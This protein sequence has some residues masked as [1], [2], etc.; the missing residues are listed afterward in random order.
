MSDH[1]VSIWIVTAS[2]EVGEYEPHQTTAGRLLSLY[3]GMSNDPKGLQQ[4]S[5]WA[6]FDNEIDAYRE[7]IRRLKASIDSSRRLLIELED[8]L[9]SLTEEDEELSADLA[10]LKG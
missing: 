7:A 9:A 2:D 6:F 3:M 8:E 1:D 10:S 4:A 5:D